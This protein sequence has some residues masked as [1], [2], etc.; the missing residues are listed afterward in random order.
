MKLSEYFASRTGLGVLAAADNT[1]NVDL[2]VYARPYFV[3]EET[4]LF[5]MADRLI[6]QYLTTNP[7]AAYL[8]KESGEGYEGKRLMLTKTKEAS[9]PA[10]IDSIFEEKNIA[11]EY[12][13]ESKYLVY[14][15]IDKV[16]PLVGDTE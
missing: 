16:L 14:F 7:K 2:A 3:D 8:F 13:S 12:R 5:I 1:G 6:H 4:I 9:D 15:R 11:P 10:E